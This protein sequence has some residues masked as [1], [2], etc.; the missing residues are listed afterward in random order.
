MT[1]VEKLEVA[2]KDVDPWDGD[3][4]ILPLA[5]LRELLE[6]A[7]NHIAALEHDLEWLKCCA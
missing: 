7:K 3:S 2:V 6:E 4:Y 5:D 1:I